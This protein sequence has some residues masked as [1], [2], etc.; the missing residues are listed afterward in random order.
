MTTKS[1]KNLKGLTAGYY[2]YLTVIHSTV[3]MALG[4]GY[5]VLRRGPLTAMTITI[6]QG[7]TIRSICVLMMSIHPLVYLSGTPVS[8]IIV[9]VTPPA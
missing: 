3:I 2:A 1:P 9:L 4:A 5:R 6:T 7:A 8:Q